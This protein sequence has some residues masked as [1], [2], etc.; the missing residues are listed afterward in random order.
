MKITN[1]P[2]CGD[3]EGEDVYQISWQDEIIK[4]KKCL[5]CGH[6]YSFIDKDIVNA[7]LYREGAYKVVDN[8]GSMFES[9]IKFE[10]GKIVAHIEKMG[11]RNTRLLDFG[12]GKGIFLHSAELAGFDVF[13]V[14]TAIERA[15][16]AK[17]KYGIEHLKSL[18]YVNGQIFSDCMSVITMLHVLEHLPNPQDLLQNLIKENLK[19]GGIVVLEV[20]NWDSWQ[21]HIAGRKWMQIDIPRHVSHFDQGALYGLLSDLGLRVMKEEQFSLHLGVLGM[22]DALLKRTI[23][24]ESS[25]IIAR[26]KGRDPKTLLLVGLVLPFALIL[27]KVASVFN[28]GGIIRLYCRY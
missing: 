7:E 26:L 13:G 2:L 12:C 5:T 27:E 20:P 19:K 9:I 1:C 6:H 15:S 16:F 18:E 28:R 10:S 17:K 14:E 11:A 25:N 22:V 21:R 8:R 24:T 23:E 3:V 4:L